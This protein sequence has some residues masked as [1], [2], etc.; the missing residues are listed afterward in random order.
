[1]IRYNCGVN[2]IRTLNIHFGEGKRD[3][4]VINQHLK[5]K[6]YTHHLKP[7]NSMIWLKFKKLKVLSPI[8]ANISSSRQMSKCEII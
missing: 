7:I 6:M 8:D 1:M 4:E 3:Y 2:D 5:K